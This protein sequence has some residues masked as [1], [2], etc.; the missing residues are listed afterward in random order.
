MYNLERLDR[1]RLNKLKEVFK[2]YQQQYKE[3]SSLKQE[4][5]KEMKDSFQKINVNKDIQEFSISICSGDTRPPPMEYKPY[6]VKI[7]KELSES[8]FSV[9]KSSSIIVQNN[10]NETVKDEPKLEEEVKEDVVEEQKEEPKPKNETIIKKVKA[11]YDFEGDGEGELQLKEG[12]LIDVYSCDENWWVGEC[13]G[14]RGY[15]PSNFVEDIE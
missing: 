13:K 11:A 10:S 7:P 6:E 5:C 14:I 4:R 12:D 2:N 15:F 9:V 8:S 1:T 3:I